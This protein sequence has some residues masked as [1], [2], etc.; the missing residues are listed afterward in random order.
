MNSIIFILA[1]IFVIF[2]VMPTWTIY[3]LVVISLTFLTHII[4]KYRE[5][6]I[7]LAKVK[8]LSIFGDTTI[9]A[10]FKVIGLSRNVLEIAFDEITVF[11]EVVESSYFDMDEIL[12]FLKCADID[13]MDKLCYAYFDCN[14]GG[15]GG[16]E[17]LDLT[18]V[19]CRMLVKESDGFRWGRKVTSCDITHALRE[20]QVICWKYPKHQCYVEFC[21]IESD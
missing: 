13:T 9:S 19:A 12:N 6:I 14:N 11:V 20:L 16:S 7:T 17:T 1:M 15:D 4:I 8:Y 18:S 3:L 5:I 10:P 2:P 21:E